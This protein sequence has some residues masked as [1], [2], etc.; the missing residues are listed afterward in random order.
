MYLCDLGSVNQAPSLPS[1][2]VDEGQQQQLS[3]VNKS[4]VLDY[5]DGNTAQES[6]EESQKGIIK[7]KSH[8]N[9]CKHINRVYIYI[10]TL[11]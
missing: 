1:I 4:H 7:Q 8:M 10:Y 3:S 11:K 2:P 5:V 6:Q 9:L